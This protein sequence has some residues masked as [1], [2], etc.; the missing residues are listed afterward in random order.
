YFKNFARVEQE[1]PPLKDKLLEFGDLG[2]GFFDAIKG[3]Y[4]A[5]KEKDAFFT[6]VYKYEDFKKIEELSENFKN[7]AFRPTVDDYE[8]GFLLCWEMILKTL[9]MLKKEYPDYP[10]KEDAKINHKEEI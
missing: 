3:A 7:E 2:K 10:L 9:S 6:K 8:K 1:L 5:M 4:L